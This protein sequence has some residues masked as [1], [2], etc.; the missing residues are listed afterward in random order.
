MWNEVSPTLLFLSGVSY[1]GFFA[2]SLRR[3]L[4]RFGTSRGADLLKLS[5]AQLL[6]ILTIRAVIPGGKFKVRIL[7][8]NLRKLPTFILLYCSHPGR[9]NPPGRCHQA[10]STVQ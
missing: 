6:R 2:G 5:Y 7:Q 4:F 9:N 10:G 8:N 1:H 3:Y